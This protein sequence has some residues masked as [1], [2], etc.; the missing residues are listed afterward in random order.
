MRTIIVIAGGWSVS[1]YDVDDLRPL[2]HVVAV[3]ESAVLKK[4]HVAVTMDRLWAEHRARRYFLENTGELWVRKGADKHLPQHP[5]LI[6]FQCDHEET[7]MSLEVHTLNGT[8]SG[9]CA[10]NYAFHCQPE[11]LF[12][13][14]YDMCKG[15][16]G[17][18]YYHPPYEWA[19]PQGA[20]KKGKLKEWSQQFSQIARQFHQLGSKVYNVNHCSQIENWPV[21]DYAKFRELT[22]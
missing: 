20:T 19:D 17:E 7:E 10:L 2:G 12:L 21:I 22:K 16:C 3:N 1:Q 9:M 6:Q 11:R 18:P 5:R 8:N 4:N 14:G 13:F 15:P